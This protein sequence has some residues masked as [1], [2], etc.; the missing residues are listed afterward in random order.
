MKKTL[1]LKALNVHRSKYTV[2][3]KLYIPSD[4][5]VTHLCHN[6]LIINTD[7]IIL[8]PQHI[9]NNRNFCE[10]RGN[11]YKHGEYA[12]FCNINYCF[13]VLMYVIGLYVK[14]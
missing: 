10:N 13:C 5:N 12:I 14:S 1:K 3:E 7:H 9:N 6:S 11:S 4:M 2:Y 8:E